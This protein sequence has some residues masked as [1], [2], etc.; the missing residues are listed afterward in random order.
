MVHIAYAK[1]LAENGFVR[2]FLTMDEEI[3]KKKKEIRE[4]IGVDVI[5]DD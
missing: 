5:G 3:L 4:S 1:F 2:Y